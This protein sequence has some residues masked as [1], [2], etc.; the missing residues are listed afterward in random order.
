MPPT[1]RAPGIEAMT[2]AELANNFF[3]IGLFGIEPPLRSGK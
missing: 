1:W 2:C 3:R